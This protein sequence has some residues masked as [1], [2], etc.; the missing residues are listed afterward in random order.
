MFQKG[1]ER[2]IRKEVLSSMKTAGH[3]AQALA[4]MEVADDQDQIR[5][6]N[7]RGEVHTGI[8]AEVDEAELRQ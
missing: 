5:L 3:G 7:G 2:F 6:A 4:K 1:P 8:R